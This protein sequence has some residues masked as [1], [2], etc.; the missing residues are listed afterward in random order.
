MAIRMTARLPHSR[1][2]APLLRLAARADPLLRGARAK[3]TPDRAAYFAHRDWLVDRSR[4]APGDLWTPQ[5]ETAQGLADT[6]AWYR[7]AG[8]L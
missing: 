1:P 5:I 3:L 2:A 7:R 8:R 4:A 6:A